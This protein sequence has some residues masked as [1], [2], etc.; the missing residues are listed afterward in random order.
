MRPP[1]SFREFLKLPEEVKESMATFD[2][3]YLQE[4]LSSVAHKKAMMDLEKKLKAHDW[5]Y[6][7]GDHK[8]WKKGRK[9]EEEIRA[10]VDLLGDDGMSLYKQYGKK[11]GVMEEA[12][13]DRKPTPYE[14]HLQAKMR[15]WDLKSLDDLEDEVL[16]RFWK[17]VDDTWKGKPDVKVNQPESKSVFPEMANVVRQGTLGYGDDRRVGEKS[18]TADSF[19]DPGNLYPEHLCPKFIPPSEHRKRRMK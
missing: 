9:K 2:N 13:K 12:K 11:A 10:L 5:Y 3:A 17:E 6:S 16:Q 8:A 4:D 18:I 7:Y 14:A 19:C 1:I 15:E